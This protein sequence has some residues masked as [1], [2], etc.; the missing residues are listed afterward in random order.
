MEGNQYF[1]D[2]LSKR[3]A[4]ELPGV[5]A[6]R[7][8]APMQAKRI[9]DAFKQDT[10]PR[11]SAVLILLYPY[12]DGLMFPLMI[13]PVYEGIHSGQ[14][15]LPGGKYEKVDQELSQTALRE[16][17]EEIGV[18]SGEITLLGR[19]ST[20]F[21]APSN[22]N[23]HPY[24]GYINHAPQFELDPIEVDHLIQVNTKDTF[25]ADLRKIK[26][27]DASGG[28]QIDAPYFDFQEKV[29][30]GATAMILSEFSEIIKNI[31]H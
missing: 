26:R 19:L 11:E 28:Y 25:N 21:V 22:F 8:M 20:Y 2:E 3:L 16:T 24:V 12:K 31:N 15:S 27:I 4:G 13:R 17:K 6:H 5:A 14:V 23:I 30:W 29:V 18:D 10:P 9:I 7:H 1:L